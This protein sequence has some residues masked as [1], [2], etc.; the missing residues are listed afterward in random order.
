MLNFPGLATGES[1][2]LDLDALE[3]LKLEPEEE[4]LE[5]PPGYFGVAEPPLVR[6]SPAAEYPAGQTDSTSVLIDVLVSETGR[7]EQV[8][9]YRGDEPFASAALAAVEDYTFYP[10]EGVDERPVPAWVEVAV[11]FAPAEPRGGEEASVSGAV[12]AAAETPV[13]AAG[14]EPA[15]AEASQIPPT[16]PAPSEDK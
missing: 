6:S 8:S 2:P 3:R 9:L 11:P 15:R 10:A 4:A 14:G 13:I 12:G 7:P 16:G 5:L 1:E